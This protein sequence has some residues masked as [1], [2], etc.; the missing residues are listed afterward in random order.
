MKKIPDGINETQLLDKNVSSQY[1]IGILCR[2]DNDD[3]HIP[4]SADVFDSIDQDQIFACNEDDEL[5][6]NEETPASLDMILSEN[7]NED[8]TDNNNDE[9]EYF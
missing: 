2:C 4:F 6:I 3:V 5:T 9:P 7:L 1:H 8:I